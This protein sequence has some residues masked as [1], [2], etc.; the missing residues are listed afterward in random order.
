MAIVGRLEVVEV[1]PAGHSRIDDGGCPV[2]QYIVRDNGGG[3][4]FEIDVRMQVDQAWSHIEVLDR[5]GPARLVRYATGTGFE[6]GKSCRV[7]VARF[8]AGVADLSH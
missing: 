7:E 3:S 2:R 4:A 6:S 8:E 1:F 5:H